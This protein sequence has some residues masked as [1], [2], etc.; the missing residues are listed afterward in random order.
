MKK[1]TILIIAALLLQ[2]TANSQ[3]SCLPEGITFTTQA[4]IDSFQINY[5]GCTEIEGDVMIDEYFGSDIV[6]LSGLSVLTSIGGGLSLIYNDSLTSITGLENV[7]VIGGRLCICANNLLTSLDGL[8]NLMSIGGDLNIGS[9]DSYGNPS[10]LDITGLDNVTSIGGSIYIWGNNSLISLTGLEN[11]TSIAGSLEISGNDAL[12]SLTGLNNVTLIEGHLLI[13]G[14]DDLT[15]LTGLNSVTSIGGLV[16]NWNDNFTSLIGLDNVTA[17]EGVIWIEGNNALTSLTGL[18]NVTAIEGELYI[19]W[20]GAITSLTGLD[21][22]DAGSITDLYLYDNPNLSTCHV[23]SICDYTVA[24]NGTIEIHD[25][26][27]GC[28][29]VEEVEEACDSI[30]S[31]PEFTLDPTFTIIPNPLEST[32]IVKYDLNHNSTV[33]LKIFDISGREIQTLVN[34]VQ[35]QGEQSVVFNTIGLKPGIYFCTLK[36]NEGVQTKKII[37]LN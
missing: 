7:T 23:Q 12:T 11:V 31:L 4:Q 37:K 8:E 30:N 17:I 5:P 27:P 35:N 20:N 9:E 28:N 2:I 19:M 22:V 16:I 24:P 25:N 13:Q 33:V 3:T 10:L 15:N 34:E 36:T 26:A 14:N 18:D 1:L 6:N 21:N 32:T 29:S